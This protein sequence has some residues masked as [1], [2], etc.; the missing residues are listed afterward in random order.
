[1]I[2]VYC[3]G[4]LVADVQTKTLT[5]FLPV[6]QVAIVDEIELILGGNAANAAVC[7][8]RMGVRASVIGRIGDDF[9]GQFVRAALA[10]AGV[11]TQMLMAQSGAKTAATVAAIDAEGRRR[12]AHTPGAT[13][14]F[15]AQD[16]D[17]SAIES[18]IHHAPADHAPF[19]HFASF[20]LLPAFDGPA[21]AQVLQ[22]ARSLGMRTSLD[23][24]WDP[25]G[26]WAA[27]L[28]PCLPH[29]D[30]VFPNQAEAYEITQQDAP[31]AMA[32][33]FLAKGVQLA[34]IKLGA[35]G[36]LVKQQGGP[37]LR[38]HGYA[39]SAVDATGA[40]D[41]FAGGFLTAQVRGW[42]LETSARFACALAALSVTDF[43]AATAIHSRE[44]VLNFMQSRE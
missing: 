5:Q 21:A 29:C 9:F 35:D 24:C 14:Q 12:C 3:S 4:N 20:F 40:G 26:Q 30:I 1:M 23:V 38:V 11:D 27:A 13:G 34:V 25:T 22:R 19:L 36:C 31:E 16:F 42:D 32:D 39:V 10:E 44:Q 17:W 2:Q 33:W 43:G 15:T 6:D 18:D 8:A 7:L 41:A 28:L 37:A